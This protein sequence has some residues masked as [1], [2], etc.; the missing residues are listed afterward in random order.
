MSELLCPLCSQGARLNKQ[1][2]SRAVSWHAL[3]RAQAGHQLQKLIAYQTYH[4]ADVIVVQVV[5]TV[6][7]ELDLCCLQGT[8]APQHTE[9]QLSGERAGSRMPESMQALLDACTGDTIHLGR[10]PVSAPQMTSGEL[11]V[12]HCMGQGSPRR[13]WRCSLPSQ[14]LDRQESW[15]P[16]PA[17]ETP[18]WERVDTSLSAM[19]HAEQRP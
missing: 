8:A 14:K 6:H 3:S 7:G 4:Q 2:H 16:R 10:L 5:G 17:S 19:Y 9:S 18:S 15:N 1:P 12:C 11:L 13:C